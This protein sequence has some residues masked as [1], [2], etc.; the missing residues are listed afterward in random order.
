MLKICYILAVLFLASAVLSG[1][2]TVN[3][4]DESRNS[5]PVPSAAFEEF[6]EGFLPQIKDGA[7][8]NQPG[9]PQI[10][11]KAVTLLVA[12]DA[13]ISSITAS[14]QMV[15]NELEGEYSIVPAPPLVSSA[16]DDYNWPE[17]SDIEKGRDQNIYQKDA[18]F[19]AE[20]VRITAKGKLREWK[21]VEISI[22]AVKYNPAQGKVSVLSGGS[23]SVDWINAP[24][25]LS[26][27]GFDGSGGVRVKKLAANFDELSPDYDAQIPPKELSKFSEPVK[28]SS[29]E[30]LDGP[31][32]AIVTVDQIHKDSD[33]LDDFI[34]HK[35]AMGFDVHLIKEAEYGDTAKGRPRFDAIRQYLADNYLA[36]DLQYVL[37]IGRPEPDTGNVPMLMYDD[38]RNDYTP[39]DPS[40]DAPSDYYYSNLNVTDLQNNNDNYWEVSVGR[41]PYYKV[42][43]DLDHILQKTIDYENAQ[44]T[45]WRA[46]VLTPVV[47][48]DDKTPVFEFGEQVMENLAEPKGYDTIRVYEENYGCISPPEFLKDE[49]TGWKVW[50]DEPVGLVLWHTHGSKISAGGIIGTWNVPSLNDSKPAATWQMSCQNAWPE[51]SGNLA[52]TILK[53]GGIN[54]IGGSRNLFYS[55][56]ESDFTD[57]GDNGY[58]YG[59]DVLAGVSCGIAKDDALRFGYEPTR[60]RT[61]MYGDPSVTIYSDLPDMMITPVEDVWVRASERTS[62][63]DFDL[64]N[65]TQD[66]NS[67]DW[68]SEGTV[69]YTLMN[70]SD[71]AYEW[72]AQ[73]NKDW[74]IL[75]NNSGAV[76]AGGQFILNAELDAAASEMNQGGIYYAKITITDTSNSK[77]S[78]RTVRVEVQEPALIGHWKFDESAGD[79]ASDSG[80][81]NNDAV[82]KN[83]DAPSCWTAGFYNGALDFDGTDDFAV[84]AGLELYSTDSVTITSW[85]KPQGSNPGVKG[86]LMNREGKAVGMHLSDNQLRYH[87]DGQGSWDQNTGLNLAQDEWAFGAVVIEP[88]KATLYKYSASA[89]WESW[90]NTR[91]HSPNTF[92]GRTVIGRDDMDG[93]FFEGILD[94]VRIYNYSLNY[95]QIQSAALS[96]KAVD[97]EPEDG[98]QNAEL[99]IELKWNCPQPG[100]GYDVYL[101]PSQSDVQNA[102]TS[103]GCYLGRTADERF[104]AEERLSPFV[105]Y[106]WRVDTVEDGQPAVKGTVWSFKTNDKLRF[107]HEAE[108][109]D[110]MSYPMVVL[111]DQN[112]SGGAYAAPAIGTGSTSAPPEEGWAEYDFSVEQEGEVKFVLTVRATDAGGSTAENNA[113]WIDITGD[114]EEPELW[115]NQTSSLSWEVLLCKSKTL[116]P[117]D[118]TFRVGAAEDGFHLDRVRIVYTGVGDSSPPPA[119]TGLQAEVSDTAVILSWEGSEAPDLEQYRIYKSSSKHSGYSLFAGGFKVTSVIDYLSY[120]GEQV[121][122]YIE[123][124]DTSG[125]VSPQS[126]IVSTV[127]EYGGG[128]GTAQ[129]PYVLFSPEHIKQLAL[130]P[131]DYS[132]SFVL[133]NDIDCSSIS[134]FASIGSQAS[135]FEGAFNGQGNRLY[136]LQHN[137]EYADNTGFFGTVGSG[138][139]VKKLA[140]DVYFQSSGGS[141]SGILAGVNQGTIDSCSVRGVLSQPYS[142]A[143]G[144]A[145]LN[146]GIISNC[147]V[148]AFVFAVEDAAG[149]AADNTAGLIR[150]CLFAGSLNASNTYG[151]AGAGAAENVNAS[152]YGTESSGAVQ[153]FGGEGKLDSELTE[154][155]TYSAWDF[156]CTDSDGTNDKWYLCTGCGEMPVLEWQRDGLDFL[157]PEGVGITE[158]AVLASSWMLSSSSPAFEPNFDLNSDGIIDELDLAVFADYWLTSGQ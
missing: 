82:L 33:V 109:A 136:G 3:S 16:G 156:A 8:I 87:W 56:G 114:D 108:D 67:F 149:I 107:Y 119:V 78:E 131:E 113:F 70:T 94:D 88:D 20:D 106:Y 75:S 61:T 104:Q 34:A 132:K 83:M 4:G 31:G 117:G 9:E 105:N 29:Y 72:T 12:P 69:E 81:G 80:T 91:A 6:E 43:A 144:I 36:L 129:N 11:W 98:F 27:S 85:I 93:R 150:N 22:P 84:A 26:E 101:S 17:G 21:L 92:A 121:Y 44:N 28:T 157:C 134:D 59:K 35:E 79:T 142:T 135:P 7:Y 25:T 141:V 60:K 158:F 77:V 64:I 58:Q 95:N 151:I 30:S 55:V 45:D 52:Y 76:D 148:D 63:I 2:I 111:Q 40:D 140:V 97:P 127:Y 14:A 128:S 115:D 147:R 90:V 57:R 39:D 102:D 152:F 18:F 86:I 155:A 50:R 74:L 24:Q 143:G 99:N 46:K 130:R 133:A 66:N 37:L 89:G 23:C 103:S 5:F 38:N 122:Y 19:P 110:R 137:F 73:S 54:T 51:N 138:G 41:I 116:S 154:K 123:A 49:K 53:N 68:F 62:G 146:Q 48:L 65:T 120:S 10:P 13:D 15:Y 42:P 112:A 139:E 96:N 47:P 124:V 71:T 118:Y 153:S 100:D 1:E 32:Y 125:N 145:G 126:E